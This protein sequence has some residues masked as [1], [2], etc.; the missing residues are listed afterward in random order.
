MTPM[1]M[2]TVVLEVPSATS[3]SSA[4]MISGRA[5]HA[6]TMRLD[7]VVDEAAEI[8]GDQPER[9]AEHGA[10]Q[11]CQRRDREDV[12]RADDDAGEDVAAELVGAE[13]VVG[14]RAAP[15]Y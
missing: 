5:R 6:S 8:A 7:D 15:A 14:A 2:T 12:A 4:M 10:E 3:A 13:P 9:G 1:T 11:G